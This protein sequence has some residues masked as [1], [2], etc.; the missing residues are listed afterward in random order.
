MNPTLAPADRPSLLLH[1]IHAAQARIMRKLACT[2]I[3]MPDTVAILNDQL[4]L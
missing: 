3:G 1:P 4:T 2:R